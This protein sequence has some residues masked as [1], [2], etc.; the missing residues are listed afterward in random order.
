MPPGLAQNLRFQAV[1]DS[2][3]RPPNLTQLMSAD[4]LLMETIC[5]LVNEENWNLDDALHEYSNV[6]HD[7][8][9]VL[10]PRP[11]QSPS[12]APVRGGKRQREWTPPPQRG[13]S[14]GK[15]DRIGAKNEED[16]GKGNSWFMESWEESWFLEKTPPDEQ[17]KPVCMRHNLSQCTSQKCTF[18]HCCPVSISDGAMCGSTDHKAIACPHRS[19]KIPTKGQLPASESSS[20]VGEPLPEPHHDSGI[21]NSRQTPKCRWN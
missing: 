5:Q 19:R 9:A 20:G 21:P 13:E 8:V 3:L 16:K 7:M 11:R 15:G 14:K 6:C 18:A 10:Q 2:G 1:S 4:R 12:A 17:T